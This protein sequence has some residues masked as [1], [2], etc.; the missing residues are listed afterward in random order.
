MFSKHRDV[1]TPQEFVMSSNF[2][3]FCRGREFTDVQRAECEKAYQQR[4]RELCDAEN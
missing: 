2:D 4:H 1:S 3:G